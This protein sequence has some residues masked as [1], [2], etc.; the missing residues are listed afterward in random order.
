MHFS[1][2]PNIELEHSN[3]HTMA[4]K[5]RTQQ[6]CFQKHF[7]IWKVVLSPQKYMF[8]RTFPKTVQKNHSK[9]QI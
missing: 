7:F 8:F 5:I 1:S 2:T 9:V 4:L 6:Y 3:E